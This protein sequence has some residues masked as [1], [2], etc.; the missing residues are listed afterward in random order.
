VCA[1]RVVCEDLGMSPSQRSGTE[2]LLAPKLEVGD[3]VRLVSPSSFPDRDGL[4]EAVRVLERWDLEVEVGE[5]ALEQWGFMAGRD[6]DRLGDLN[7]A[8]RDPGVRAVIAAMGGAGAYR[9]ADGIDFDAVRA[10]PKPVLGFSDITNLHLALWQQCRLANVHGCLSGERAEASA[11]QLLM[12]TQPITL[13]RDPG[14]DSAAIEIPGRATGFLMG[15][16]L[17]QVQGFIGAG[18]PGLDGAI[19]CIE[20]HGTAADAAVLDRILHHFIDSGSLAGLN[21]VAIGDLGGLGKP[22]VQVYLERLGALGIPVL[23]GLPF[24]HLPDQT[25]MPLGPSATLDTE[26]GTLTVAAAVV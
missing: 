24:G 26:T 2:I 6:E 18:M 5:H 16:N 21:G 9:I 10:D 7:D 19:L 11:R 17:T 1:T 15:G 14:A 22:A 3:R 23:G 13:Q 12:T 8:F 25:C 4:E 20:D